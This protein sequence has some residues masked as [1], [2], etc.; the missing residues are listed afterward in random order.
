MK[1]WFAQFKFLN[2]EHG[3]IYQVV[4]VIAATLVVDL[5]Q[6]FVVNQLEKRA[7][8]TGSP[9]DDSLMLAVRKPISLFLWVLG[10]TLA[11]EVAGFHAQNA[12]TAYV[13]Q[14]RTVGVIASLGWFLLR[15]IR[16]AEGILLQRGG[17]LGD[18]RLDITTVQALRKLGSLAVWVVMA[19]VTLQTLGFNLSAVLT[20]G[21]I[22]GV[23]LGFASRDVVANFFGGLMVYITQPFRVGDWIRS[24]DRNIEGTVEEIGW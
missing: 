11:L 23:A 3:W 1:Q 19:I 8:G 21:G 17:Q 12:V 15:W 18:H 2:G 20:V 6:R 10:I 14:I 22:G 9:W 4:I 7:D 16:K 13:P 24:P 5:V